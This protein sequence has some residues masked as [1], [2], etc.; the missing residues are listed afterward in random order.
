VCVC[1]G[2][3]SG[4]VCVGEV[5][6][7]ECAVGDAGRAV[8]RLCVSAVQ[9]LG[10]SCGGVPGLG[11]GGAEAEGQL[12]SCRGRCSCRPAEATV[13]HLRQHACCAVGQRCACRAARSL[14][15][16]TCLC[17]QQHRPARCP[18]MLRLRV[19]HA[20]HVLAPGACIK[21]LACA[22]IKPR[23]AHHAALC[24]VPS[25]LCMCLHQAACV[26]PMRMAHHGRWP[27]SPEP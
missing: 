5:S 9:T 25:M 23:L 26:K 21:L 1:V 15:C 8:W 12:C 11:W 19:W 20:L 18:T 16:M 17:L 2:G 10:V 27:C 13:P 14:C 3:V 7:R 6:G 22:C 4:C 24:D